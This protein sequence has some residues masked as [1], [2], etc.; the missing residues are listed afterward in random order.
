MDDPS[1]RPEQLP[2]TILDVP[3]YEIL[4]RAVSRVSSSPIAK[5]TYAQI[6]DGL[7]LSDVARDSNGEGF[8]AQHPLLNEHKEHV[9]A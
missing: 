4:I 7:P 9:L 5:Q 8:C 1:A 2:I 3:H 6:V